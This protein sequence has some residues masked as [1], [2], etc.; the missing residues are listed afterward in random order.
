MIATNKIKFF[1]LSAPFDIHVAGRKFCN[2]FVFLASLMQTWLLIVCQMA[3]QL[4]MSSWNWWRPNCIVPQVVEL[5]K[6]CA[7]MFGL[8]VHE[9]TIGSQRIDYSC[10]SYIRRMY[11]REFTWLAGSYFDSFIWLHVQRTHSAQCKFR[12]NGQQKK[13]SACMS[14]WPPLAHK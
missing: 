6:L 11:G 3:K 8:C 5:C 12:S 14:R 9:S 2:S 1:L 10:Y 7:R 4:K 13:W